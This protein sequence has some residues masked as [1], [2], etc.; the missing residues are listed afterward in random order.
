MEETT[1]AL[2]I[3]DHSVAEATTLLVRAHGHRTLTY[4]SATEALA[5]DNF[6]NAKLIVCALS[7][8]GA[9][10]HTFADPCLNLCRGVPIILIANGLENLRNFAE[11]SPN[12]VEIIAKPY[13]PAQ[14]VAT[15]TREI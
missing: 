15:I 13:I 5:D 2:V 9:P 8:S 7:D 3:D 1:V 4:H 11:L 6:A 14:L 10:L 12:I